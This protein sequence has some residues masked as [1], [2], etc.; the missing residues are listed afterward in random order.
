MIVPQLPL[1]IWNSPQYQLIC[2]SLIKKGIL[3]F[4]NKA[5]LNV[6]GNFDLFLL[7]YSFF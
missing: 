2:Y 3:S 6:S 7:M 5:G 1:Y 4:M